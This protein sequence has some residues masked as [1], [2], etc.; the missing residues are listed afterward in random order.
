MTE[1]RALN[2]QQTLFETPVYGLNMA[3]KI[4]HPHSLKVT[5]ILHLLLEFLLQRADNLVLKTMCRFTGHD[6]HH[7]PNIMHQKAPS[8]ASESMMLP[9]PL[10]I[11][12]YVV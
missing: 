11:L 5:H 8:I 12:A 9:V 6:Q 7:D 2:T 10:M 3:C 1:R 4:H